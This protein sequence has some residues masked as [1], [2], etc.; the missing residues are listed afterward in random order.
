MGRGK[1]EMRELNFDTPKALYEAGAKFA[2]QTDATGRGISHQPL[3]AAMAVAYGLPWE[4]ALKAVTINP[5]EI[6]GVADRVGSLEKGKDADLRILSG[7]PFDPLT[8]VEMVIIDGKVL[9]KR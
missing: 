5:A 6:L 7:D 3:C 1:W 2:I 4:A 9:V 8:E